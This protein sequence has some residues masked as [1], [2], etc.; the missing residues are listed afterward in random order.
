VKLSTNQI[1]STDKII[2]HTDVKGAVRSIRENVDIAACGHAEIMKDVDGRNKPG[3][4]K[5]TES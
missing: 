5:E 3:H 4:D 2:R 1:D